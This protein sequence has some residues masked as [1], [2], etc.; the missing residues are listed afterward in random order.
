MKTSTALELRTL[1]WISI[2]RKL[3]R[4]TVDH[5]LKRLRSRASPRPAVFVQPPHSCCQNA[6]K[7]SCAGSV[8]PK[9]R[10][11]GLSQIKSQKT[12]G[13]SELIG[14]VGFCGHRRGRDI[15]SARPDRRKPTA[16]LVGRL[17]HPSRKN[18]A[19]SAASK[20][21]LGTR[22]RLNPVER[23]EP[24]R[25]WADRFFTTDPRFQSPLILPLPTS[26]I[27]G[28]NRR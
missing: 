5:L 11:L 17:H 13:C 2:G 15:I 12:R 27:E 1:E 10:N 14:T 25:K 8:L 4:P 16:L 6:H 9:T 24:N 3:I 18:D 26:R 22:T 20:L 28:K 19:I 23:L 21:A 7:K